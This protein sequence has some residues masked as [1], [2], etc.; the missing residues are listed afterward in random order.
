MILDF[1]KFLFFYSK[2]IYSVNLI[3]KPMSDVTFTIIPSSMN[4]LIYLFIIPAIVVFVAGLS[5]YH[6]PQSNGK[7]SVSVILIMGILS[8]GIIIGGVFLQKNANTPATVEIGNKFIQIDSSETGRINVT[9]SQIS[10]AYVAQIGTGNLTLSRQH[11]LS[12]SVDN[13]GVFTL[14]NGATAY[15]ISSV[16]TDLIIQLTSGKYMIVGNE[17]LTE[18][19]AVF[20]Q[21][22]FNV[23]S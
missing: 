4:W 17:N 8:A 6:K 2:N 12:N 20:S 11:G 9:S 22:V 14:G 16:P 18:M 3:I 13:F 5:K 21:N 7:N 19:V 1:E 15:V 10:N 23:S